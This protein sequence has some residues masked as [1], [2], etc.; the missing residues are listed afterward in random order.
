M[1]RYIEKTGKS[2]HEQKPIKD[3]SKYK[4]VIIKTIN[5]QQVFFGFFFLINFP[6]QGDNANPKEPPGVKQNE[7]I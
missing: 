5:S 2:N 1:K 7:K 6:K 3:E 4:L